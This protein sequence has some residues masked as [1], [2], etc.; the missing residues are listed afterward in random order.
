VKD[1]VEMTDIVHYK[2]PFGFIGSW[3][4]GLLVEKS[5]REIFTYRY[6]KIEEI[7]GKWPSQQMS[8]SF[9]KTIKSA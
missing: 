4:N 3:A 6:K 5:L 7:Y 1:G 8:I 9:Y 2:V